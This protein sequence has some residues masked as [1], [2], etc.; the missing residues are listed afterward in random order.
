M[1][2]RLGK[3]LASSAETLKEAQREDAQTDAY[4]RRELEPEWYEQQAKRKAKK[5]QANGTP[6]S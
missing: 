4:I 5:A 6:Q 3:I 2:N 1:K